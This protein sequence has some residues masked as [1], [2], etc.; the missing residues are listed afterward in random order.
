M[1]FEEMQA[2]LK[3]E[4]RKDFPAYESFALQTTRMI[5]FDYF[6]NHPNAT[7][8]NFKTAFPFEKLE[9]KLNAE[10]GKYLIISNPAPVDNDFIL[11]AP[12][13][14]VKKTITVSL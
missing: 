3:K 1:D 6:I 8:Q 10:D 5:F 13:Y 4:K 7:L 11:Y 9:T 12:V 14:G 2:Q